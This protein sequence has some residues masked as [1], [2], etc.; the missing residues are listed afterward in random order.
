MFEPPF[1]SERPDGGSLSLERDIWGDIEE[2]LGGHVAGVL[3]V[4]KVERV[5]AGDVV[6]EEDASSFG[7]SK[8]CPYASW[9]VN[10]CDPLP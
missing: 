1:G 5:D 2:G 10:M 3:S 7:V 6:E 8:I 4:L 9:R